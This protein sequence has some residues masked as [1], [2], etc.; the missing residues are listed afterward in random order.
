[1]FEEWVMGREENPFWPLGAVSRRRETPSWIMY[2]DFLIS[3]WEE[4][5]GKN[6]MFMTRMV[7]LKYW[8]FGVIVEGL[9]RIWRHKVSP[10]KNLVPAFTC[11]KSFGSLETV[12][13]MVLATFVWISDSLW[14]ELIPVP[15]RLRTSEGVSVWKKCLSTEIELLSDLTDCSKER[16]NTNPGRNCRNG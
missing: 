8:L 12:R 14:Y 10:G 1:M 5:S 9:S 6:Y 4:V 11:S 15:Q 7:G 13:S 16:S 3:T 2:R